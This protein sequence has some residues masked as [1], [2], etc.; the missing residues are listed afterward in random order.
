MPCSY[1]TEDLHWGN[2]IVFHASL[3]SEAT[4]LQDGATFCVVL[5]RGGFAQCPFLSGI[6]KNKSNKYCT[7]HKA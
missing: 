6:N 4:H 3:L 2:W 5:L 7:K 1:L